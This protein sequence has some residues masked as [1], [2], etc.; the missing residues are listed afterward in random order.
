MK[1][2]WKF[3][4]KASGKDGCS[5]RC[6]GNLQVL[7]YKDGSQVDSG[8]TKYRSYT[9]NELKFTVQ[10]DDNNAR[11]ECRVFNALSQRPKTAQVALRVNCK[12]FIYLSKSS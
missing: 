5:E 8:F 11:F 1:C 6:H 4:R 10:R 12:F 7:W 3:R 2:I 9:V